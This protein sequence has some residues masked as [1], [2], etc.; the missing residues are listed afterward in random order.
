VGRGINHVC[1]CQ[2]GSLVA[3]G[4]FEIDGEARTLG[5]SNV[6]GDDGVLNFANQIRKVGR[7]LLC[8]LLEF[9]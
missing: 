8:C 7:E 9:R 1:R 4:R 6:H 3:G 5:G 2:D